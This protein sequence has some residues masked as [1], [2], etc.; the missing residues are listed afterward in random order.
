MPLLPDRQAF[1]TTLL[2]HPAD[3]FRL[4]VENG[5]DYAIYLLDPCGRFLR[6]HKSVEAVSGYSADEIAPLHPLDFFTGGEKE[7]V[8]DR[9]AEVFRTGRS[10]VEAHIVTKAGDR[11]PYYFNGVSAEID[12]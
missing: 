11:L 1:T 12:G 5:K 9:I 6:W 3:P 2:H 8:R 4:L 7:I 10:E